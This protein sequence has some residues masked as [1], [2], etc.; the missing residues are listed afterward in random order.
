MI[1]ALTYRLGDHTTADDASRYRTQ[2]EVE[3]W[4]KRSPISRLHTYMTTEGMWDD[5]QE[6]AL[7]DEVNKLIEEEVR[8]REESPPLEPTEM[9]KYMY[10]EMPWNLKEQMEMLEE[11]VR[12]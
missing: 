3:L 6:E 10:H 7:L 8:I 1:E 12:S 11:E 4:E 5:K 2:E 9:F